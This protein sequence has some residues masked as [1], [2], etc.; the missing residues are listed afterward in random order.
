M[1][2]KGLK[3]DLRR[4]KVSPRERSRFLEVMSNWDNL[5][6]ALTAEL[7]AGYITEA[8]VLRMLKVEI[9][10][11]KRLAICTRL[12]AVYMKLVKASFERQLAVALAAP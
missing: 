3:L 2:H 5:H 12:L 7:K 9:E 10:S 8:V 6:A 11:R 4:V 1:I